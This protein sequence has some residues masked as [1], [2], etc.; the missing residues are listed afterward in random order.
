MSPSLSRRR[1]LQLAG[2]ATATYLVLRQADLEKPELNDLLTEVPRLGGR[3]RGY[4]LT[5]R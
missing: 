3:L 1:A 2:T 5:Q 4:V